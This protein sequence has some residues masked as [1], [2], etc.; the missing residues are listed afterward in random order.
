MPECT[1]ALL[2]SL[3]RPC[4]LGLPEILAEAHINIYQSFLGPA[5]FALKYLDPPNVG[6][7]RRRV[8]ADM[9]QKCKGGRR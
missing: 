1:K 2:K 6:T 4:S 5:S 7:E 3:C 9:T 8:S